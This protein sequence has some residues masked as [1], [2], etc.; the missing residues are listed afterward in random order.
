MKTVILRV[1]MVAMAASLF[2]AACKKGSNAPAGS[3]IAASSSQ[4]SMGLKADN[5]SMSVTDAGTNS[6]TA[7]NAVSAV[8]SVNITSGTANISG[9]KFEARRHN[10]EVEVESKAMTS[11]D[12]FAINP[13]L[14]GIALDT[15]A[16]SSIELRVEFT[17]SSSDTPLSLKGTFTNSAGTAIPLAVYIN[18]NA[19]VKVE[20]QNVNVDGMTDLSSFVTMHINKLFNTVRLS[21][22]G[23]ATQT[24]GTIVIS[25]S[26]N[27]GIY[28]RI[29][30]NLLSCGDSDGFQHHD[31]HDR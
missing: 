29:L 9:F 23:S 14:I 10:L 17:K 3:T 4:L 16:Y 13:A 18:D 22:L 26:S 8:G 21:D 28:N 2:F 1:G 24:N 11:I 6:T 25:N 30:S 15:G 12:L 5:A 19:E 31:R 20:A 7:V 27:T